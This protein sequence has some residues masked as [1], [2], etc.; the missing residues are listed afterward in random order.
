MLGLL[1]DWRILLATASPFAT[2]RPVIVTDAPLDASALAVMPGS[3]RGWTL[4]DHESYYDDPPMGHIRDDYK[5]FKRHRIPL[6]QVDY[7]R[8]VLVPMHAG[9]G[10]FFTN[11]TWHRSEPNRTGETHAFYAIAYKLGQ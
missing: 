3:Q 2:L 7:T 5:P 4:V 9:D 6:Q 11:F 10:L 1:V 8:E